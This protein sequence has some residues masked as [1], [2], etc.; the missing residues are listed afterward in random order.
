MNS[1]LGLDDI[2]NIDNVDNA[3][4]DKS[5]DSQN[6]A[7]IISKIGSVNNNNYIRPTKFRTK[8]KSKSKSKSKNILLTNSDIVI[9]E[10]IRNT[11]LLLILRERIKTLFKNNLLIRVINPF[12]YVETSDVL[13]IYA[14][15][16]LLLIFGYISGF[17]LAHIIIL[18]I[19][20]QNI[21]DLLF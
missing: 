13:R 3:I 12:K 18:P 9:D 19:I 5:Y 6:N 15:V 7:N 2:V 4:Q 21:I 1:R 20:V 14:H 16:F 8:N 17:H 11:D 10:S